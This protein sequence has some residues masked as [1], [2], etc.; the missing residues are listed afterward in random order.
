MKI[1]LANPRGFCAGVDRAIRIVEEAIEKYGAPVFV[2]NEIVH[3]RAVVNSL[4]KRGAIFV[5]NVGD[6]PNE[7]VIIFSA[8]GAAIGAYE[9]AKNKKLTVLDASC[10]LVK[11]VHS[12]IKKYS[13]ENAKIILIGHEGHPEVEGHLGQIDE[14]IFLVTKPEDIEKLYFNE[15]EKL[16]YITQ[17][18]LSIMEA[19]NIISE[20][21]KK[22]PK[23][24]GPKSGDLCYATTNRQKA[25]EQLAGKIDL[26]LVVGSANSSNSNR[27]KEL[28]E[29]L[30]I[31]SYLMDEPQ[32][33]E[34][35]WFENCKNLGITSGASAP[36]YLVQELM[37]KICD[38]FFIEEVIQMQ[39]TEEKIKFPM[40]QELRE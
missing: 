35:S 1:I 12:N 10:P 19:E 18:T 16:A 27:L 20:L 6:V 2:R 32:N 30:G 28:G 37:S 36:E 38:N 40:P 26:L 25:I 15:N 9:E 8:H 7:A 22:F 33:M 31:K 34:L 5:K 3:N 11:K 23:I 21:K 24:I 17:T 14:K 29:S 39:T 4:K 13:K